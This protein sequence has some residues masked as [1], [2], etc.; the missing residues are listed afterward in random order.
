MNKMIK[1]AQ[2]GFTLIELM[3]VVAIIGILAA[4]A[5]PMFLDSMKSAKNSEAKVQLAKMRDTAKTKAATNAGFP[6][7]TTGTTPA[8]TCCTQNF[9]SKKQCQ[10]IV[11]DWATA[12]WQALDFQIDEPFYFQYS[13]TSAAGTDFTATATGNMD[14]DAVSIVYSQTGTI[15]VNGNPTMSAMIEPA[16]NTD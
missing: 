10:P 2:R 8:A 11:A 16:P 14:C 5:I 7:V 6:A 3:I 13:Y 9:G 1:K 15:D 4:V 12:N